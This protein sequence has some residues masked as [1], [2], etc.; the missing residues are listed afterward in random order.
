MKYYGVIVIGI[1]FAAV[2][3]EEL[4]SDKYDVLNVEEVLAHDE[5]RDTYYNCFMDR[6]PCAEDADYWKGNFPEAVVT[7]CRKCTEWQ[8]VAFD[9]I[10]DWYSSHQPDNW[11]SLIDKMLQEAKARNIEDRK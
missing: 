3:C 7:N 11:N 1:V 6:G 4:Y 10:A 8:K 2:S 9:K 5:L